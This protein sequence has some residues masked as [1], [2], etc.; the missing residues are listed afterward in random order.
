MAAN[1]NTGD[2]VDGSVS[3][4]L[5]FESSAVAGETVCAFFETVKDMIAE[6]NELMRFEASTGNTLDEF[7]DGN[8]FSLTV[9][10]DDGA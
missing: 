8:M 10:D 2:I 4:T 3:I 9:E 1:S 5:Y 7:A 6:T